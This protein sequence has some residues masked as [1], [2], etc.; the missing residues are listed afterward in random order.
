MVVPGATSAPGA[1]TAVWP[2]CNSATAAVGVMLKLVLEM[3]KKML[4]AH[5]TITRAV[6][7]L[8]LGDVTEADPSLAVLASK[9]VG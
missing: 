4:V 5:L 2:I 6:L 8:M 1:G 9:L 3:S 7:V